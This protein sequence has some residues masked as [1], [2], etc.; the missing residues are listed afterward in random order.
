M[1]TTFAR[2][3]KILKGLVEPRNWVEEAFAESGGDSGDGKLYRV[4]KILD[5]N[6][7]IF[8]LTKTWAEINNMLADGIVYIPVTKGE[9]HESEVGDR[10]FYD[11]RA[12]HYVFTTSNNEYIAATADDPPYYNA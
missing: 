10:T 9:G 8:V 3:A 11:D 5:S 4:D 7:H 1:L 2:I 6:N 12:T